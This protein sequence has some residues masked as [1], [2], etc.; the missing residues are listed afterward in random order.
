ELRLVGLMAAVIPLAEAVARG[1]D[2]GW[3]LTTTLTLAIISATVAADAIIRR[4]RHEFYA[5]LGLVVLTIWSIWL[6]AAI[7]EEQA[8]I[9]PFGLLLLGIGWA[10]RHEQ[11][12]AR[13]QMA[14]W[15]G[16]ILLLGSSFL[17]SLPREALGYT[18]LAS[19]EAF[20]ALVIGIRAHSRHYVLAGG[21]ALL[22]TT[23][24]QIGPAFIDLSRWAQLGITGTILLAA[25]LLA[26]FR[27]EQLLATR[28][29]LASEWRQW[30]V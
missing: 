6:D 17:Q 26:L 18:A 23:L 30:D 14:S 22:A 28:R 27:K 20:V 24:A 7:I 3:S 15:L 9:L 1:L 29:R 25:G 19:F 10:E 11:H 16:L 5:S 13:F 2:S 21:V 4:Q 12:Q 8:Y